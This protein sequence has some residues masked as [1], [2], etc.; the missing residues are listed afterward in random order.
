MNTRYKIVVGVAILA[1]VAGSAVANS[2]LT[3]PEYIQASTSAAKI[4]LLAEAGDTISGVAIRGIPDGM[5]AYRNEDGT[6]TLLSSHEVPSY[7]AIGALAK[8]ADKGKPVLGVSITKMI[9][10]KAGDRVSSASNFIK[11]WSFY[12]YNT[13]SKSMKKGV[14]G[15]NNAVYHKIILAE[16]DKAY[17]FTTKQSAPFYCSEGELNQKLC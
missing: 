11:T 16:E 10:N 17:L 2:V 5:G 9:L 6:I 1:T 8:A 12:N 3:K 13:K 7:G 14:R 15:L 4:K